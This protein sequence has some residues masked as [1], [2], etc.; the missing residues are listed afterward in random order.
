MPLDLPQVKQIG[1]RAGRYGMHSTK[2]SES[3]ADLDEGTPDQPAASTIGQV[4]T[5]DPEDLP[6][7]RKAMNATVPPIPTAIIAPSTPLL[8]QL[9]AALAPNVPWSQVLAVAHIFARTSENYTIP[10]AASHIPVAAMIDE[11]TELTVDELQVFA[12]APVNQR[13]VKAQEAFKNFVRAHMLSKP[14]DIGKWCQE[15][16]IAHLLPE[17]HRP[18]ESLAN[19]AQTSGS[20]L[21]TLESCHKIMSLYLWLSYRLPISFDQPD[22]VRTLRHNI[23]VS[24]CSQSAQISP[25]NT[26]PDFYRK[27]LSLFLLAEQSGLGKRQRAR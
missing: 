15:Q 10:I 5:L 20:D 7:L 19:I 23:E 9:N 2:T 8:V 17:S 25:T 13:D 22:L 12:Q 14:I 21:L 27:Q 4:T 1:G 11:F 18:E 26:Q 24:L 3:A 6:L 16:G